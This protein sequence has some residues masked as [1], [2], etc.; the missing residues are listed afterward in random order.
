[1]EAPKIYSTLNYDLFKFHE[2][3]RPVGSNKTIMKSIQGIDLTPYT[4]IIVDEDFYIIDGQNRFQA[5]KTMSKPIYYVIM[6]R[7]YDTNTAMISLNKSQKM[8][9]QEEFLHFHSTTKGGCWRDLENFENSHKLGISNSVVIYPLKQINANTI[10]MGSECFVKNPNADKIVSFLTSE[11]VKLLRYS[12][13]R[14][15]V[16]AVRKAFEIYTPKQ[17]SKLRKRIIVIPQMACFEQYLCA[18]QNIIG[19]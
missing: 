13:T 19:K 7:L 2:Q 18:F 17:I 5:C 12:R 11:E 14:A 4:P 3:N 6:P 1:M 16:L 9:R 15:F 10:R 8:W